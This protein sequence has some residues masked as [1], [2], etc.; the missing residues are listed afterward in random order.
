MPFKLR[1]LML[2]RVDLVPAGA[3]QDAHIVLYKSE[4]EDN[5]PMKKAPAKGAKKKLAKKEDD[6]KPV[7]RSKELDKNL[8]RVRRGEEV[9]L[10]DEDV[11][12]DEDELDAQDDDEGVE[13]GKAKSV[14]GAKKKTA[15]AAD[16][17]DEDDDAE[18]TDEDDEDEEEEDVEK[19]EDDEDA[20]AVEED[21][22]EEVEEVPASV[23]KSLPRKVRETIE[24]QSAQLRRLSKSAREALRLATIEKNRRERLEFVEKAKQ[25]LPNLTGT[26]EEKGE[27]LQAI[28]NS[29]IEKGIVK[30]LMRML[31]SGDGAVRD[32][33]MTETGRRSARNIEADGPLGELREYAKEIQKGDTKLTKEQAFTKACEMHPD[34]FTQYRRE[35]VR[36]RRRDLDVN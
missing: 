2:N 13:K 5:V 19:S 25:Q 29:N 17:E 24:K 10:D 26:A 20:D 34:L 11:L 30:R 16:D 4:E 14:K 6:E 32:L 3:N 28:H 21:D 18:S 31:K 27:V 1:N 22:E 9:E 15:K 23:L 12:D 8:A 35:R 33:L 36:E 7:K